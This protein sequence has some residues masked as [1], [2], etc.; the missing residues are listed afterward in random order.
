M[1]GGG[2]RQSRQRPLSGRRP[3]HIGL[4]PKGGVQLKGGGAVD[5]RQLYSKW[6]ALGNWTA[7]NC[8]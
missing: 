7:L 4:T 5:W 8:N 2:C 3:A 6:I 1:R